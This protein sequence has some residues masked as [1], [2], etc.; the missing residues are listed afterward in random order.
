MLLALALSALPS[1]TAFTCTPVRLWDGDGPI[2]CSEG[3]R[4]RLN[5]IAARE[6]NGSCRKG[7]PCPVA[8]ATAA[9]TALAGLLGRQVGV[10]REG[11]ALIIGPALQCRSYGSAGGGRTAARCR[12]PRHGD[13]SCAM[14]VSGTVLR[15]ARY[16]RGPDC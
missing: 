12:S 13:L 3:P 8:S 11:H 9:R 2:W 1:G 5:G 10:S 14:L 15:W 4:V 16:W 7:H 6:A